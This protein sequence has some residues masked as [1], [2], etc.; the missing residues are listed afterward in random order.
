MAIKVCILYV[1]VCVWS[2][3]MGE[4]GGACSY[5][6]TH[7]HAHILA[8]VHFVICLKQC[9]LCTYHNVLGPDVCGWV[10]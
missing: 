8:T 6:Y 1:A 5:N 10:H 4:R 7:I 2:V 3:G 9:V